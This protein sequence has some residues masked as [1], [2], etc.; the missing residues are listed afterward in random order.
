MAVISGE[1]GRPLLD[2][3]DGGEGGWT[4]QPPLWLP[5]LN[6]DGIPELLFAL[7]DTLPS[8]G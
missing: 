7:T 3:E 1:S 6:Q 8:T 4:L 2:W 5:D